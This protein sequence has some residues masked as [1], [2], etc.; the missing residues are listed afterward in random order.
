MVI[1]SNILP[2]ILSLVCA[3]VYVADSKDN[4]AVKFSPNLVDV[5][6]YDLSNE[7]RHMKKLCHRKGHEA[8][9]EYLQKLQEDEDRGRG[10][11]LGFARRLWENL[12]LRPWSLSAECSLDL[13]NGID[14]EYTR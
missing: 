3:Q 6:E 1:V 10:R 9:D 8:A 2:A 13:Y 7:E 5:H 11:L 4:R 14:T 12:D